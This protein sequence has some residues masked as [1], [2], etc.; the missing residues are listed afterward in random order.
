M[1][2]REQFVLAV[3]V[4]LLR[5]ETHVTG[6]GRPE[7]D[8]SVDDDVAAVAFV[9]EA[10]EVVR[11]GERLIGEASGDNAGDTIRVYCGWAAEVFR[12]VRDE[13]QCSMSM[14]GIRL[15]TGKIYSPCP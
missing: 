15:C 3:L 8:A 2:G 12:Q 10:L 13:A 5:N 9:G 1:L 11:E 7:L 6:C 4:A 14:I